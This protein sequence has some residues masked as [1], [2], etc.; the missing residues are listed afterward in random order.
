MGEGFLRVTKGLIKYYFLVI[1]KRWFSFKW[2]K[3]S[4]RIIGDSIVIIATDFGENWQ[5][6]VADSIKKKLAG[7]PK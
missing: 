4:A 6:E 3:E 7:K 5:E 2:V 1:D